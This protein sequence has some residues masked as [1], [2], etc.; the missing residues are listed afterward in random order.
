MH[1]KLERVN[2]HLCDKYFWVRNVI[3][4]PH[5]SIDNP[6]DRAQPRLEADQVEAEADEDHGGVGGGAVL[7]NEHSLS[8][9]VARP[10]R[11]HLIVA[12]ISDWSILCNAGFWLVSTWSM[13]HM[14]HSLVHL[15]PW[16]NRSRSSTQCELRYDSININ[17]VHSQDTQ[18]LWVLCVRSWKEG[19][20]L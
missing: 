19:G 1:W 3:C 6:G 9:A 13:E 8:G 2:F 18:M 4:E 15:S 17:Y 5:L 20:K 11:H 14:T 12:L 16:S 10:L 7:G